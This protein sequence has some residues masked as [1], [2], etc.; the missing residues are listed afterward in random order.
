MAVTTMILI[1]IGLS[2][3][4]VKM[5]RED[6]TQTVFPA[7]VKLRRHKIMKKRVRR[8]SYSRKCQSN[9]EFLLILILIMLLSGDVEVN[10][11]PVSFD[12]FKDMN[13]TQRGKVSKPDMELLLNQLAE[14]NDEE[15]GSHADVLKELKEIK[16]DLK[17]I[18]DIK[19][20]VEDH[21]AK[22]SNL[23]NEVKNLKDAVVAQQRFWEEIDKEKRCKKLI[24]LGIEENQ[25]EDKTKVDNLLRYLQISDEIEIDEMKRLGRIRESDDEGEVT[26][27]R[28]LLVEVKSR[29]MRNNVL[30][31][32]KNLKDV[33]EESWMKTVFI[34]ADEHPEIRKEMKRLNDVFKDEKKKAE[35]TGIEV[36]FDRKARKVTRNG[37]II[38]SFQVLSL[39]Q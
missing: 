13:K 10:P 27:K 15:S 5:K 19:V 8:S 18:K 17:D 2:V 33:D 4:I 7:L 14:S 37:E 23:Q 6:L 38:D 3:H 34:K 22:I 36:K 32:A 28:P 35:N 30:K 21:E 31:H 12:Q 20:T 26:H 11:G 25:T 1:L 29:E 16:K 24:F 39:F 9:T